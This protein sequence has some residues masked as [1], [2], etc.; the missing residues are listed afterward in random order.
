MNDE[1]NIL[2]P[3]PSQSY[4]A[5]YQVHTPLAM[6]PALEILRARKTELF[7]AEGGKSIQGALDILNKTDGHIAYVLAF[8]TSIIKSLES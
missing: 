3:Y 1:Y 7:K 8:Y 5:Y 2:L 4:I 6:G